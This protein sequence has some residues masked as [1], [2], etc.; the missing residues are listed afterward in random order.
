V[1]TNFNCFS[2][3]NEEGSIIIVH[4][5]YRVKKKNV[6]IHLGSSFKILMSSTIPEDVIY[7]ECSHDLRVKFAM[8]F[9]K[10]KILEAVLKPVQ[11]QWAVW[12]L[13]N[14]GDQ[15]QNLFHARQGHYHGAVLP[16]FFLVD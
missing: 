11:K 4:D 7:S 3:E 13:C 6:L 14:P 15:I 12:W 10:I 9:S 8:V 2:K 5:K 16:S 1:E